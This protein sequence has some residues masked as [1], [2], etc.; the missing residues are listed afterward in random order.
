MQLLSRAVA[1][2]SL[3][4]SLIFGGPAGVGK[5]R[6]A[7][8]LAQA[9]NCQRPVDE[10]GARDAC[11]TCSA[12]Q[13]IERGLHPDVFFIQ[14]EESGSTKIVQVREAV[15]HA[16]YRPFEGRRRVVAFDDADTLVAAAQNALLKTLEETPPASVFILIT[17]RPD[18]LLTTVR[19]RCPL[20]RFGLL[21]AGEV[22]AVLT[23]DHRY[24]AA[25]AAAAASQ[26]RGSVGIALATA[27][28]DLVR[29]RDAARQLLKDLARSDARPR[30]EAA[31]QLGRPTSAVGERDQL[32]RQ[33]QAFGSLL[34]DLV[35]L[36]TRGDDR[37]LAN[38]DLKPE[39]ERF[40]GAYDAERSNRAFALVDRALAALE[41]NASPKIVAGWLAVRV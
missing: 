34:R 10:A 39:L 4:Q 35:L 6:T 14:P 19:S 5:R 21:S 41:R 20:V 1:R 16:A 18:Q 28:G 33:L 11:G 8:A 27:G 7:V 29:A 40:L 31:R 24:T 13:R 30:I 12:C 15:D 26:A 32:A 22:A 25:E 2:A 3:P 17:A 23:R 37:A 36:S 38:R 9:L